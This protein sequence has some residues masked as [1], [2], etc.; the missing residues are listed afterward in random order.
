MVDDRSWLVFEKLPEP[1]Q[2]LHLVR[3]ILDAAGIEEGP[4]YG[5][6][7]VGL[8]ESIEKVGEVFLLGRKGPYQRLSQRGLV[9]R[10]NA[11]GRPV[12]PLA[13]RPPG[14]L[15]QGLDFRLVAQTQPLYSGR[16]ELGN[17]R[18]QLARVPENLHP[19]ILQPIEISLTQD[20]VEFGKFRIRVRG[21][22]K[23]GHMFSPG[24]LKRHPWSLGKMVNGD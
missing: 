14:Q 23:I 4:L 5:H 21:S 3:S 11:K 13:K 17:R 15:E 8:E 12:F 6:R 18:Y 19:E 1:I 16:G 22:G 9:P 2:S 7:I 20:L 10:G 24:Y